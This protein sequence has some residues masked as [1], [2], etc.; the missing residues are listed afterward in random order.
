MTDNLPHL[1]FHLDKIKT[2][3]YKESKD[4]LSSSYVRGERIV[5]D[6]DYDKLRIN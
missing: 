5:L 1:L 2:D 6:S 3:Y 4:L